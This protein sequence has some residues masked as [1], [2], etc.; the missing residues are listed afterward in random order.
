MSSADKTKLGLEVEVE[1]ARRRP[2]LDGSMG[3]ATSIS[4]ITGLIPIQ[5]SIETAS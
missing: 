5:R 2:K 4:S 1:A 3:D